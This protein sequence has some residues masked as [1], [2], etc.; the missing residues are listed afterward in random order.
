MPSTG[1]DGRLLEL[2]IF[3][4]SCSSASTRAV[5]ER[6]GPGVDISAMLTVPPNNGTL[7]RIIGGGL[8]LSRK[9][10]TITYVTWVYKVTSVADLHP[11]ADS[12]RLAI[13][14]HFD[15]EEVSPAE[16][17]HALCLESTIGSYLQL[18][19]STKRLPGTIGSPIDTTWTS[20]LLRISDG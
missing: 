10:K 11:V 6:R 12:E 5:G 1:S 20:S 15:C 7:V 18:Q 4:F 8:R 3:D 13:S 2:D 17:A 9:K 19:L 14:T 16:G